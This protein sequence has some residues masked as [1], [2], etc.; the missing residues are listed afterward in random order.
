[1]QECPACKNTTLDVQDQYI[2]YEAGECPCGY[3]FSYITDMF[4]LVTQQ[5]HAVSHEYRQID[6]LDEV[7]DEDLAY[8][9]ERFQ[10]EQLPGEEKVFRT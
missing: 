8:L 4:K 9:R 5:A 3:S 7:F 10:W 1:M 6:D 2:G